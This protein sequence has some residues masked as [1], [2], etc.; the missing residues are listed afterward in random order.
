MKKFLI[1]RIV[2]TICL[3][4]WV[5]VML[6]PESAWAVYKGGNAALLKGKRKQK[7]KEATAALRSLPRFTR[8][9]F[10]S[11][12]LGLSF[13]IDGSQAIEASSQ[14]HSATKRGAHF[15]GTDGKERD[16][17]SDF[18]AVEGDRWENVKALANE[19]EVSVVLSNFS[20]DITKQL[21]RTAKYLLDAMPPVLRDAWLAE[22]GGLLFLRNGK[23][24]YTGQKKIDRSE[25]GY[26][27]PH[28]G[29]VM[30]A[31]FIDSE[32]KELKLHD[33]L[34]E[35]WDQWG[36]RY[37]ILHTCAFLTGKKEI[38]ELCPKEVSVM[39]KYRKMK[40]T[41]EV[42]GAPGAAEPPSDIVGSLNAW[43]KLAREAFIAE[44]LGLCYMPSG[45]SGYDSRAWVREGARYVG[46]DGK[47]C[48]FWKNSNLMS[49]R[50][51]WDRVAKLYDQADALE[52]LGN[53]KAEV[54]ALKQAFNTHAPKQVRDRINNTSAMGSASPN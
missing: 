42:S 35:Y 54:D 50:M 29:V 11:E 13:K 1:L 24:A 21:N 30:G 26:D 7:L 28:P 3:A 43:P 45:D 9:A 34:G 53:F 39:T 37:N 41:N 20:R 27:V 31:L 23:S 52:V 4:T 33:V 12:M 49:D 10:I 46:A 25:A 44:R 36:R 48:D 16:W 40:V 6:A 5:P 19:V 8:E 47:E 17:F 14:G 15:V 32:G 18:S 2:W 22:T 38:L 51:E